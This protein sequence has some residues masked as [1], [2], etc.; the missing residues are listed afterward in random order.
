[1]IV[2][3]DADLDMAMRSILFGA[4]G[5][6]GQRCTST[7]RVF[8]HKDIADGLTASLVKA[9]GSVRVGDPTDR[10]NLMGPLIDQDASRR[11]DGCARG[12]AFPGRRGV[13]RR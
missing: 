1:M 5:T 13:V 7:R 6:A 3:D 11:D 10:K 2:M 9:Y 8:L 4:V 12:C